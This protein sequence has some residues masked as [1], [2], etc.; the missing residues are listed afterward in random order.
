MLSL[1]EFQQRFSSE[2]ACQEHLFNMRW[3]E[4]F[5]CPRCGCKEYYHISSR[6]HYQCRDCNYQASLT[7][8]TIFHKTRTALRKWFWA[9]F[10]VAND[11]RGF[12]ALSLQ[13]SIDVSYP[14]AWLML[15]KIR[16]AM[17]DRELKSQGYTHERVLSSSPEAEEK[18][19]WVHALISNAKAFMV[20]TFHGLD[21]SHL[22]A[23]LDEFC[24]RF[25]RRKWRN[26]LFNR[27]LHACVVG[28]TVTYAE[29]TL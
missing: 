14:T 20:G 28:P 24:Y 4:G 13:H 1:F 23:Y 21:K 19:H 15:H 9:I 6:R 26:Q 7:A 22:Q 3:A 11:K 8:G 17:S 16:T 29:L 10:L 18:L 27:L 2:E 12:S 25:N 5:E